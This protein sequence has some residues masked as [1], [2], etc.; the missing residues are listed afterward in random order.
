MFAQ[1]D[2]RMI[3]LNAAGHGLPDRAVRDRMRAYLDRED[4]I[5]PSAAEDEAMEEMASVVDK[6]AQVIGA[7]KDNVA[8]VG[9]TTV[10]WN[11][12]VLSLPLKDRRVLVAPGEWSSNVA[13]LQRMG[14]EIEV[15][16]TDRTGALDIK[17]L[18]NRIDDRTG[19]ICASH[20]CSLTGE[21]Y[22]LEQIGAL[23]RPED[24]MF[25]VDAAQ[26]IGQ[27]E[28]SIDGLN[29]DV[30]AATT[31]KWL[32][33]PRDTAMLYVSD[34]ALAHMRPNPAP[35]LFN[36]VKHGHQL[37]DKPNISRFDAG[38]FFAPQRLGLGVALG[39]FLEN[40]RARFDELASKSSLVRRIAKEMG[41]VVVGSEPEQS[42]IVTLHLDDD[43][44][45]AAMT[46]LKEAG[47]SLKNP[48]PDC[49]PLRQV[50]ANPNGY[51]R[52]AP[53]IYNTDDEVHQ[54]MELI[55]PA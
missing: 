33:G 30:L 37:K 34:R 17:A 9:T 51:I 49:E 23:V 5:G 12:A 4:E 35:R 26:S 2:T 14:A 38:S 46:R 31:R 11:A 15:M 27:I 47:V 22:P 40:P 1:E 52:I 7:P 18:S 13:V 54:A 48:A 43:K 39:L 41:H 16:P 3:Y 42:A 10:A 21:R 25:V 36:I 45:E 24:C 19:A 8:L 20:V 29:C 50:P 53:H 44:A 32:R 6:A 28:L 55:G